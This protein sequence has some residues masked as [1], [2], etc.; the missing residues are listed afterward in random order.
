M[1]EER[2]IFTKL[3]DVCILD[4]ITKGPKNLRT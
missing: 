3:P 4:I 2:S 1:K